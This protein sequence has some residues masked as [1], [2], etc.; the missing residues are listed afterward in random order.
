MKTLRTLA[1]ALATCSITQTVA[2]SPVTVSFEPVAQTVN[3]NDLVV[4][5]L[6][7]SGL[8]PGVSIGS[9]DLFLYFDPAIIGALLVDFG[10]YL[11]NPTS[12][13][14]LTGFDISSTPGQAE[15]FEDSLLSPAALTMLQDP[16]RAAGFTLAT[17][18]FIAGA[19]GISEL[20]FGLTIGADAYGA[21]L[22]LSGGVGSI[23]VLDSTPVPEPGTFIL[24]AITFLPGAALLRR[25]GKAIR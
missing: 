20:S 17:L 5:N 15:V 10:P 11:G 22:N 19:P 25:F 8:A 7:V 6:V 21:P 4:V 3:V 9:F 16:V 18:T 13:E 1:F 23:N 12:L 24:L 14:A 2:A